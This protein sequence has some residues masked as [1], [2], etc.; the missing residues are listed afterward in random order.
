MK[1]NGEFGLKMGEA[2][3]K[4]ILRHLDLSYNSMDILEC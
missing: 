4:G 2:V 1:R 3:N